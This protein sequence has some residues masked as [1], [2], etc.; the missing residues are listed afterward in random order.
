MLGL[1]NVARPSSASASSGG[2]GR[3]EAAA[4][5][6]A[7]IR[8]VD[9]RQPID[10]A[11]FADADAAFTLAYPTAPTAPAAQ[12]GQQTNGTHPPLKP[13]RVR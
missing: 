7:E 1:V 6:G 2:S 4:A 9:L 10:E 12:N 3:P 8:G 11:T 5:A 13:L